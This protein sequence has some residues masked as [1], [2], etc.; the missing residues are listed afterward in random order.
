MLTRTAIFLFCLAVGNGEPK[1]Y[2]F[3][4]VYKVQVNSQESL[5]RLTSIEELH[6]WN[7]CHYGQHF[8]GCD[9]MVAPQFSDFV[10]RLFFDLGLSYEVMIENVG[11]LIQKQKVN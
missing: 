3:Y 5:D 9:V 7:D 2:D 11:E 4:T 10:E 6:F 1:S 8:N